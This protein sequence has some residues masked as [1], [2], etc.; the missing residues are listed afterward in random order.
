MRRNLIRAFQLPSII[1]SRPSAHLRQRQNALFPG[2]AGA[3]RRVELRDVG[4]RQLSVPLPQPLVQ[5]R[6]GKAVSVNEAIGPRA[7]RIDVA[8]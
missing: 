4:R 2:H 5:Q 6:L 3:K 1:Q 7:Q 8:G